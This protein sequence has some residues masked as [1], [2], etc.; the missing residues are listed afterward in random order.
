MGEAKARA[1]QQGFTVV[2]GQCFEFDRALPYAPSI[3]LLR[4]F[5]RH[6]LSQLPSR[7]GRRACAN[8]QIAAH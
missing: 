3:D 6:H 8:G 7:C 1:S 5:S 2:H 4:G